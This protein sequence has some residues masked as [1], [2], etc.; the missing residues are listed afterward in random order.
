MSDKPPEVGRLNAYYYSFDPTGKPWIDNILSKVAFAGK[1]FHSTEHWNEREGDELSNVDHIQEAARLAAEHVANVEK[2]DADLKKCLS[3]L[4]G[5]FEA[6]EGKNY[7][8]TEWARELL[9]LKDGCEPEDVEAPVSSHRKALERLRHHCC[10]LDH[11]K[12]ST[13]CPRAI[14]NDALKD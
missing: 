1:M 5:L 8:T 9:S 2:K 11:E 13:E 14:A 4:L 12:D 3:K 7:V 6:A 10:C